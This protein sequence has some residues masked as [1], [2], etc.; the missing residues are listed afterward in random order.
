MYPT[1]DTLR[2]H[3]HYAKVVAALADRNP[4]HATSILNIADN[5]DVYAQYLYLTG[6]Q[7]PKIL[8]QFRNFRDYFLFPSEKPDGSKRAGKPQDFGDAKTW[9]HQLTWKWLPIIARAAWI[10]SADMSR[11]LRTC[12]AML[13]TGELEGVNTFVGLRDMA[14]IRWALE[15][16]ESA[17]A[18]SQRGFGSEY[19]QYGLTTLRKLAFDKDGYPLFDNGRI[20]HICNTSRP[21]AVWFEMMGFWDCPANFYGMP[22]NL[23]LSDGTLPLFEA[24]A[25][26]A[27]NDGYDPKVA[28]GPLWAWP[29]TSR[30]SVKMRSLIRERN[31][32]PSID[33]L[34]VPA[35]IDVTPITLKPRN[36]SFAGWDIQETDTEAKVTYTCSSPECTTKRFRSAVPVTMTVKKAGPVGTNEG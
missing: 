30:M 15:G 34:T 9:Q 10:Y 18:V 11:F 3:P 13:L 8:N 19:H 23:L 27:F 20:G 26:P 1:P 36:R 6:Q 25:F 29:G 12:E 33:D 16:R 35:D 21:A 14:M 7:H 4:R 28:L 5:C 22:F 32:P 2:R 31:D 24:P 17:K